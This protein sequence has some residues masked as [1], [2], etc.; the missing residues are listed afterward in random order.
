MNGVE[1]LG[2]RDKLRNVVMIYDYFNK[3]EGLLV[4]IF[5]C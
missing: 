1:L 3:E 5:W 4:V 2:E